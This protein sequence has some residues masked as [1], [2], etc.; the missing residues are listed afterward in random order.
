M[1]DTVSTDK[2]D[3]EVDGN[4]DA[5]KHRPSIGHDPIIHD[6]SPLLSCQDLQGI[7]AP[8]THWCRVSDAAQTYLEH[9]DERLRKVVEV[10]APWSMIGEVEFSPKHLHPQQREDD[11][12]EEEEEEQRGDGAHRVQK[13]SHEVTQRGPVPVKHRG[14]KY[15]EKK[16]QV[17]ATRRLWDLTL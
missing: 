9:A 16:Q 11:N 8:I 4:Q 1:K 12:E 15:R 2:E 13:R 7:Q 17:D 5:W 10:A 3:D 14:V 6:V